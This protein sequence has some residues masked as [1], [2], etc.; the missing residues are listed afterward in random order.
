MKKIF[1][2]AGPSQLYPTLPSHIQQ[3][4]VKNIGSISHRSTFYKS[5]HARTVENLRHLM[6]VPDTN[7]ILFFS[8]ANEIWERLVQNCV[9]TG[10]FHFVNGAFSNRFAQITEELDYPCIKQEAMW[11]KGFGFASDII[12][13]WVEMINFTHNESSTG[14][15]QPLAVVYEYKRNNPDKLVTLDVVSSAPFPELDFTFLDAVYFS[16]QKGMGLPAGLGVL[17]A[18]EAVLQKAVRKLERGKSIGSY[19]RFTDVWEKAKDS[20]TVETPNIMGIYLLGKVAEDMLRKG[21]QQIR[22]D[23]LQKQKIIERITKISDKFSF[24]VKEE[25]FCSPTVITIEAGEKAAEYIKI[26][27][28]EGLVIGSGYGKLKS[29]QIRIANF[30]AHTLE[31]FALLEKLFRKLL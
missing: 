13:E 20:Q 5:F 7:Q 12:P 28:S 2:T 27:D 16:V 17:I 9:E 24:F 25:P 10:S 22:E 18:G 21:V 14:V 11:G 19:H 8:S 31:D 4:F 29:T 3:A 23:I 30:P 6:R 15:M 26:A 1:F